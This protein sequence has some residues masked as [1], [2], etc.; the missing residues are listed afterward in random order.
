MLMKHVSSNLT[1]ILKWFFPAFWLVFFG[2]FTTVIWIFQI[3]PFGSISPGT[4]RIVVTVLYLLFAALILFSIMRLKRVEM[5]N[6]VVFV[7][8]YFK[9]YQ[10]PWSN[11]EK[12]EERIYPFFHVIFVKFR[13]PGR[14]GKRIFFIA[15]KKRFSEFLMAHPKLVESLFEREQVD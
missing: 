8:N 11:I 7:S 12:I 15:N 1:V 2:S 13:K 10:Y 9:H 6:E 14:F 4:F 3:P 5:S